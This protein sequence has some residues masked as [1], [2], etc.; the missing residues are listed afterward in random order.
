MSN[1]YKF[2][3]T[4]TVVIESCHGD[5]VE[6]GFDKNGLQYRMHGA[7]SANRVLETN[8]RRRTARN[9][10]VVFCCFDWTRLIETADTHAE[11]TT[12]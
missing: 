2:A 7:V 3:V 1:E 9:T 5:H 11:L 8:E 6:V 10:Q 12:S 4:E